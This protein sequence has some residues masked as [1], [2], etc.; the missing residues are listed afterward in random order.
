MPIKT[1]ISFSELKDWNFCPYYRKL[2][3]EDGL[4][5]Y[6]ESVFTVFG[7]SVHSICENI[8]KDESAKTLFESTFHE[9]IK[10]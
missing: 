1:H 10:N 4:N 6:T 7:T 2:T 3:Q 5:P 9:N 8:V